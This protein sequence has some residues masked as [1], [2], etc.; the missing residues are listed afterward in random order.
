MT[1]YSNKPLFIINVLTTKP[2][3]VDEFIRLQLDGLPRL[4]PLPGLTESRLFRAEDG[5]GA[6]IMSGYESEEAFRAFQE[7]AAFAT[8][9]A[10]MAPLVENVRPAF[11]RLIHER[12]RV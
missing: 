1:D 6:V 8:E 12:E 2:G 7:S 5:T 10:K 9:R 3:M 4:G 11:Y